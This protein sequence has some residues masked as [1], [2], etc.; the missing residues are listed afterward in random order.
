MPWLAELATHQKTTTL[1]LASVVSARV[2][3]GAITA[4]LDREIRTVAATV[5]RLYLNS[6]M[7]DAPGQRSSAFDPG[8][9]FRIEAAPA[10][11]QGDVLVVV[12]VDVASPS[13]APDRRASRPYGL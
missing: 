12:H 10:L 6:R 7:D 9:D 13:A 11:A 5:G 2:P 1:K 3:A 4:L 8:S